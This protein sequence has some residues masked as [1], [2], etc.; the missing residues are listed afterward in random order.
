MNHI[1]YLRRGAGGGGSAEFDELQVACL[2]ELIS[3]LASI[4]EVQRIAP[5]HALQ[6]SNAV[7]GAIVQTYSAGLKQGG[8]L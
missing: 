6:L 8:G 7:A 4:L 2:T 1:L 5:L 3:F